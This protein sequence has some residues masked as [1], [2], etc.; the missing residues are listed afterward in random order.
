VKD[1]NTL[2]PWMQSTHRSGGKISSPC[3]AHSSLCAFDVTG[4]NLDIDDVGVLVDWYFS[5][6]WSTSM[7]LKATKSRT[8]TK[9]EKSASTWM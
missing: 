3:L 2:Y 6:I 8:E 4:G 9:R 1:Q 7:F 5:T